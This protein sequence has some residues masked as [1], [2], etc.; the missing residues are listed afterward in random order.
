M[1]DF[2]QFAEE[3]AHE[4]FQCGVRRQTGA[5]TTH[6]QAYDAPHTAGTVR[7]A[8]GERVLLSVISPEPTCATCRARQAEYD[9]LDVG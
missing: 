6:W 7:A 3:T 2:K 8:C 4:V 9:G 5:E 1:M